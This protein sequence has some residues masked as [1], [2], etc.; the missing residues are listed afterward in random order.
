MIW[1]IAVLLLISSVGEGNLARGQYELPKALGSLTIDLAGVD[2]IHE[3]E[4]QIRIVYHEPVQ[5]TIEFGYV[6]RAWT[7]RS[8]LPPGLATIEVNH[9]A[10]EPLELRVV[11][12]EREYKP[13]QRYNFS[14]SKPESSPRNDS[15]LIAIQYW[16]PLQID[17]IKNICG[18]FGL[19]IISTRACSPEPYG[20]PSSNFIL[21]EPLEPIRDFHNHILSD[22]RSIVNKQ[23]IGI[24]GQRSETFDGPG[25]GFHYCT[26]YG[27]FL[28]FYS[29]QGV[30]READL[31]AIRSHPRVRQFQFDERYNEVTVEL[32]PGTGTG[33]FALAKEWS[34]LRSVYS[35]QV[36]PLMVIM[37]D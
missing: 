23:S 5:D 37:G 36:L 8:Q 9:P 10:Y 6:Q 31:N 20:T 30:T 14:L 4:V 35:M 18:K 34:K 11:L 21:V 7:S 13:W 16:D 19:N 29:Y 26:V 25:D 24:I 22:L 17:T 12:D 32:D 2:S 15:I 27:V 33:S 28:R 3:S 1:K